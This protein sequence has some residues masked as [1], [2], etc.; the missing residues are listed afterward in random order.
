MINNTLNVYIVIKSIYL[1]ETTKHD[2]CSLRDKKKKE[3]TFLYV[4]FART[5]KWK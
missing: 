5:H 1:F 2:F 3:K 4:I